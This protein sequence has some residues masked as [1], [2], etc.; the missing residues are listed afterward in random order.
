[1]GENGSGEMDLSYLATPYSLYP[2][3]PELAFIK[4][5]K[6]AAQLMLVGIKCYSPIVHC[7]PLATYGNINPLDNSIW[8]PFDEVM[9]NACGTLIVANM[10]GWQESKGVAH[11]IAFFEAA[12]KSI[13][14][15][16]VK[17]L[18]MV[19]RK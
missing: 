8:L 16:D 7:H 11:E 15:L 9:M 3:G 12:S 6:L 19:K 4:A 5:A 13:F 18:G 1:M 14:D 2:F 10:S 17:T